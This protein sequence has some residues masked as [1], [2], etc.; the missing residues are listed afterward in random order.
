VIENGTDIDN[1][2]M[3]E[4]MDVVQ[5]FQNVYGV[6]QQMTTEQDYYNN[7]AGY[8]PNYNEAAA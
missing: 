3:P 7:D 1:W 5:E 4:L 6:P 2:T 8:N